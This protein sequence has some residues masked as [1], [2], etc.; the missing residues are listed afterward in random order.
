[1][2]KYLLPMARNLT[3]GQTIKM[4]DLTGHRYTLAQRDIA[5]ERADQLAAKME[6]RTR[7]PW[8]GFLTEYTPS[9][10]R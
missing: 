10:R 7:N 4:Q 6:S 9:Q 5:Q 3:T 2:D 8:V 1:M